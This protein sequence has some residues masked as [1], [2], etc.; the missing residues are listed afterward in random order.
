MET[1][2]T[3]RGNPKAC[4]HARMPRR[5]LFAELSE[6]VAAVAGTREAKRNMAKNRSRSSVPGNASPGAK[7]T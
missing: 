6:G 4:C 3:K 7:R 5:D 1:I 2:S